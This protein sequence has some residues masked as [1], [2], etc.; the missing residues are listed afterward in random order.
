M[1]QL[2]RFQDIIQHN[3]SEDVLAFLGLGSM[4][5][6]SR[7]DDDS[8]IDFFMI[9]E[10][11]H[12]LNYLQSV[13]WL[14]VAPIV[15][16]YQET[17]DGLKVIYEDG[18]LLEFA[19][20]EPDELN[21]IPFQEGTIYYS[22]PSFDKNLLKPTVRLPKKHDA[23]WIL[24]TLL[25]NLYVGLLREHRGEHVAAFL[26]IQVYATHHLLTLLDAKQDDPFVVER[27]I[28]SRLTLDYDSIYPGISHNKKAAQSILNSACQ[29][30]ECPIQLMRLLNDLI[31]N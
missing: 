4:H 1:K 9:V 29:T 12:K 16:W 31:N 10:K 26:M 30:R 22:K 2:K 3:Q 18:I 15:F 11:G 27:R 5:D 25:S 19:V 28:E 8:D 23:S 6:V 14:E 20:F 17:P 21:A 13:K 24:S 7:L